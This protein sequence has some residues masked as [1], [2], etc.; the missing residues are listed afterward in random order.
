MRLTRDTLHTYISLLNHLARLLNIWGWEDC[1]LQLNHQSENFGLIRLQYCNRI[2][3]IGDIYTYT[4]EG[5]IKSWMSLKTQTA[6]LRSLRKNIKQSDVL[7]GCNCSHCK[8]SV[9]GGGRVGC[10]LKENT[11]PEAKKLANIALVKLASED[12]GG[13]WG[14]FF[15]SFKTSGLGSDDFVHV[16]PWKGRHLAVQMRNLK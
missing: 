5:Q 3:M 13:W 8:S 2:Q 10:P 14:Y 1:Q 12:W 6:E 9:R 16:K 15:W 7:Q 11:G 4:R